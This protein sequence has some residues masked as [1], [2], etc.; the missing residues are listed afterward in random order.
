MRSGAPTS[1]RW[2]PIW[3][4]SIWR[5]TSESS[6]PW[7]GIVSLFMPAVIGI[8]ADRWVPAQR[9]PPASATYGGPSSWPRRAITPC[10]PAL[11]GVVRRALHALFAQRGLLHADDRP[12]ELGGLLRAGGVP[13]SI[14]S[15]GLP[16]D[17]RDRGLHLLDASSS[18]AAG[19]Q[20]TYMQFIQCAVLGIVLGLP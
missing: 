6:M 12:L 4:A 10:L 14:R 15:R 9:L 18:H 3:S 8:V 7:Q 11:C 5:R 19:F 2:G 20:T 17:P 13:V 1:P 16:A